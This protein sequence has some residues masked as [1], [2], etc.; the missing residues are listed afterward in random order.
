MVS[1]CGVDITKFELKEI[2]GETTGQE[3]ET[4]IEFRTTLLQDIGRA[5]DVFVLAEIE[6]GEVE[7][8]MR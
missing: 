3:Q 7:V 1:P 5:S 2:F 4:Q 8:V 6:P